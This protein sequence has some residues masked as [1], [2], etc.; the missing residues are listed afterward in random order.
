MTFSRY[1]IVYPKTSTRFKAIVH[2]FICFFLIF[3]YLPYETILPCFVDTNSDKVS[4]ANTITAEY[5]F[6]ISYLS[7]NLFFSYKF[8]KAMQNKN[9][10]GGGG[11]NRKL[12]ILGVKNLLHNFIR[13]DSIFFSSLFM[14]LCASISLNEISSIGVILQGI[15]FNYGFAP[16]VCNKLICFVVLFFVSFYS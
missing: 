4:T 6:M 2:F 8:W 10:F 12:L 11:N 1:L 3:T 14:I 13:Y 9:A 16:A 5:I 15:E 7:F